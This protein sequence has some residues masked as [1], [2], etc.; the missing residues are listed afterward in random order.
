MKELNY[1]YSKQVTL[2]IENNDEIVY[3]SLAVL[4]TTFG[5][6]N[7]QLKMMKKQPE[8]KPLG[9]EFDESETIEGV[10]FYPG[11]PSDIILVDSSA[12]I[13]CNWTEPD[14]SGLYS[15]K[16]FYAVKTM[17]ICPEGFIQKSG[18][19]RGVSKLTLRS[20]M[21][22]AAIYY[23]DV[24]LKKIKLN[25]DQEIIDI[26]NNMAGKG[27][28]GHGGTLQMS[29]LGHEIFSRSF[30]SSILFTLN[31]NGK[32]SSISFAKKVKLVGNKLEYE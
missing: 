15:G 8:P 13:L 29:V 3:Y 4:A 25:T 17:V 23:Q 11:F 2:V 19:K 27:Y 24:W 6:F 28:R 10:D 20:S 9:F 21:A 22:Y 26:Y 1:P 7:R 12:N 18:I 31:T 14:F 5:E 32:I 16:T 30:D